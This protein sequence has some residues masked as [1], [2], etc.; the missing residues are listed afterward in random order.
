MF[1]LLLFYVLEVLMVVP[2]VFPYVCVVTYSYP[3]TYSV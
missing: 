2:G 3:E 1:K